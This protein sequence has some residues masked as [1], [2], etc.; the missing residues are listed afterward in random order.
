MQGILILIVATVS[1]IP[2]NILARILGDEEA[3]LRG[4]KSIITMYICY[5]IGMAIVYFYIIPYR[6]TIPFLLGY[7]VWF[8]VIFTIISVTYGL[9]FKK[10]LIISIAM[11]IFTTIANFSTNSHKGTS[12]QATHR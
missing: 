7:L 1:A 8:I 9:G 3:K 6:V 4:G 11:T 5:S 10:T 2:L 12:V